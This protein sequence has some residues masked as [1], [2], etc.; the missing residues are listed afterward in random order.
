MTTLFSAATAPLPR[1]QAQAVSDALE[2][3]AWPEAVAVSMSETDETRDLWAV[4]A[5]YEIEPA[6]DDVQQALVFAGI[7]AVPVTI[8][9]LPET[10]WVRESLAGLAPVV[11]GRL[12]VH[13]SHDRDARPATAISLEIDAGLAFG[14]GHHHTTR[15]CL[16]ALQQV[17]KS[18][19]PVSILDVGCGSGVL[20]I[21]AARLTRAPAI[22]SDIDPEAVAVARANAELNGVA[23]LVRCL[24]APGLGHM[25]IRKAGPYGLVF[26]NILAMPLIH[27]ATDLSRA[28]A[29]GGR[30]IL[31]GLTSDQARMVLAAYH[32][33]GMKCVHRLDLE[34]WAILTLAHKT[35]GTA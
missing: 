30:L 20:A 14:T 4:E 31:A 9:P 26:A 8:G 27:L 3:A 7:E 34:G 6:P 16:L 23:P 32:A 17:L 12:F 11:T 25:D 28:V 13:G 2:Q 5:L 10:D 19:T 24:V 33:R 22:A 35:R 1:A 18:S 15:G 21:A 29:P